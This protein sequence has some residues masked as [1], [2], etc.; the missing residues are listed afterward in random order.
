MNAI[1]QTQGYRKSIQDKDKDKENY[2][3]GALCATG[4][5]P[6]IVIK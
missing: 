6:L 4:L 2:M 5:L 1:L 3:Y